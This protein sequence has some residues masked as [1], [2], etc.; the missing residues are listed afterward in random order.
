[1]NDF[2]RAASSIAKK[3]RKIN[4]FPINKRSHVPKRSLTT[5]IFLIGGDI[6][7][8]RWN[9]DK[10]GFSPPYH[11]ETIEISKMENAMKTKLTSWVMEHSLGM[12]KEWFSL[13]RMKFTNHFFPPSFV[14]YSVPGVFYIEL[15]SSR[16]YIVDDS[17]YM[18]LASSLNYR[19]DLV[20]IVARL[21]QLFMALTQRRSK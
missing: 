17:Y 10:K 20:R 6:G 16:N 7:L 15:Q 4:H 8:K 9:R 13:Q 19:S 5:F 3:I 21:Q 2:S 1:M 14:L 18:Y 12:L 11:V